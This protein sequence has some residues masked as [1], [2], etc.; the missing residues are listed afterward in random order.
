MDGIEV[1]QLNNQKMQNRPKH[2]EEIPK[3]KKHRTSRFILR[4][5]EEK[6]LKLKRKK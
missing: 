6:N 3:I 2:K 5:N 1:T 4:L